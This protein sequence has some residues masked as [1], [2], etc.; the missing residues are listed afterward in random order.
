M[1]RRVTRTVR[2]QPPKPRVSNAALGIG[3]V[4]LVETL[5]FVELFFVYT[6]MKVGNRVWLLPGMALPDRTLATVSLGLLLAG[7][8]AHGYASW[9]V[10]HDDRNGLWWGVVITFLL[11]FAFMMCQVVEFRRLEFTA[12]DGAFGSNFYLLRTAH[13]LHVLGG[14]VLM[15]FLLIRVNLG[16]FSARRNLLVQTS[17]IY[18]LFVAIIWI[19]IYFMLYF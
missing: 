18:W 11:G 5:F 10:R 19:P 3:A 7:C 13:G 16:Q 4:L 12:G 9:A 15:L 2:T 17:A 1:Q 6:Y 8:V 14:M